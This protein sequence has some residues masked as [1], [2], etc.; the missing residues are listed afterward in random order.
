MKSFTLFFYR[1]QI[2][3][4]APPPPSAASP[5]RH[6]LI[7]RSCS[8]ETVAVIEDIDQEDPEAK[9]DTVYILNRYSAPIAKDFASDHEDGSY[10]IR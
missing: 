9:Y 7:M 1:N 10:K 3:T 2:A 4:I 5:S 6:S 8:Q